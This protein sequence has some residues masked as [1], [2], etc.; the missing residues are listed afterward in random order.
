M[1]QA[2]LDI[3]GMTCAGCQSTVERAL[4]GSPGVTTARVNLLQHQASVDYDPA[5]TSPAQL[6]AQVQATG[7]G[8]ALPAA[9]T[10]S[11][12]QEALE[13]R[14]EREYQELKRRAII[15]S[16]IAFAAMTLGMAT[17]H[18]PRW[19]WLWMAAAGYVAL[20]PGRSFYTRAW[21]ALRH[22]GTN[23]D[24]L[25]ALGTGAAIGYSV[26]ET[27]RS[28]HDVYFE[29]AI[30]II[31]LI[32]V[33][34]TL[35]ARATRQTSQ[36]LRQLASLQPPL[37]TV[38]RMFVEQSVPAA[39]VRLG[40]IVVVKPGERVP[41]DGL[42]L[43]GASAIDES[44][45]TGE[46]MPVT[47]QA[48]DAVSAGTI[49]TLGALRLKATRVGGDTTL[50]Q[51][52]R[53]LREAQ[54][55]RA[56]LEQLADRV[57]AIFVPAVVLIALVTFGGWL[58]MGASM[59][60]ALTRAIA[61]LIISCPCAMG[62]AVPAAVMVATGRGARLGLLIRG[63]EA[64]ER[65]ARVGRVAFDKTGTLTLGKPTVS[66][67][68]PND[69]AILRWAAAVERYSEH[70]LAKGILAEAQRRGIALGT[71]QDFVAEPGVGVSGMVEGHRV[72]VGLGEGAARVQV[73]VDARML[74]EIHFDDPARPEAGAAIAGLK[75][76]GLV[77]SLLSGDR[78]SAVAE[79][80]AAVGIAD[81]AGGLLPAD[82]LARI[83]A[84]QAAGEVV[85]MVGDGINDAP[86]LAQ[87]DVGIALGTGTD[88]AR[89]AAHVTLLGGRLD[90]VERAIR[91]GRAAVRV[92]KQNLFWAMV[93]NTVAIPAA[94]LGW[95]SPVAA[96]AAMALSSL[97][98]VVNSLRLRRAA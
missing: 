94:A 76:M 8:A 95:T 98:V 32:L 56:P 54:T 50:E 41:V 27:L 92:M 5:R 29:A 89:E 35:E 69:N 70:P 9:G 3:T 63:G 72:Q 7:Y 73:T 48:G 42:V 15:T 6:V 97:S 22:G 43:S 16:A 23:M 38:V 87:A 51:V 26:V 1:A 57:S 75:Q 86:A 67:V 79:L 91:L 24:V 59:S 44:M 31:A 36:A 37:A 25:V 88:I 12:A 14:R 46:P 45:L 66:R 68:V 84:W 13:E 33:G 30:T 40:E 85:A 90:R 55:S 64:L 78:S 10:A 96:S 58:A 18:D 34:R 19:H 71:A 77:P 39:E 81:F 47:K 83:R 65:L 21:S 2:T 74:G 4:A 11:Q 20:G 61:V 17:M 52:L 53:L 60:T 80:A 82:K 93:Y 28:G 62:L 49:N